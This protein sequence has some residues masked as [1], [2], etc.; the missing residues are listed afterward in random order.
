MTGQHNIR[1]GTGART[2]IEMRKC[3]VDDIEMTKAHPEV[4]AIGLGEAMFRKM[5]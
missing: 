5:V 2:R 3:E 1:Q 4:I